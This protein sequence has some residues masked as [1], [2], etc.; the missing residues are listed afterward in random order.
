MA[1]AVEPGLYFHPNDETVPPELRGIGIRIED[2]VVVHADRT[3]ILTADLP[4]TAAGLEQW[5]QANQPR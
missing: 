1:L 4:I 2:N 3:E 5:V